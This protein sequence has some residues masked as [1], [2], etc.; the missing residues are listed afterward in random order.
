MRWYV[1]PERTGNQVAVGCIACRASAP[2]CP[3]IHRPLVCIGAGCA[4]RRQPPLAHTAEGRVR[5]LAP[6]KGLFPSCATYHTPASF[7]SMKYDVSI[8]IRLRLLLSLLSAQEVSKE[9]SV[10]LMRKR[11]LC[12][13][14]RLLLP[15]LPA[16]S[17]R[18][19]AALSYRVLRTMAMDK[20]GW[21]CA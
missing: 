17:P 21:R 13:R 10:I 12:F 18:T 6:V 20:H 3:P 2:A 4:E 15:P 8:S 16:P 14:L 11:R 19:P 9:R 7:S 1:G 5:G